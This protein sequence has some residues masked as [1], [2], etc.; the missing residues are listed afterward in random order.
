MSNLYYICI[1][2]KVSMTS[3]RDDTSYKTITSREWD[4][5]QISN[6]FRSKVENDFLAPKILE[7][8]GNI[9]DDHPEN[10][11]NDNRSS[12][13]SPD[14]GGS[15]GSFLIPGSLI[16]GGFIETPVYTFTLPDLTCYQGNHNNYFFRRRIGIVVFIDYKCSFHIQHNNRAK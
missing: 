8:S 1:V 9:L 16:A 3:F 2:W 10:T 7:G 15:A 12:P 11:G 6:F 14:S 4:L 5:R 13:D